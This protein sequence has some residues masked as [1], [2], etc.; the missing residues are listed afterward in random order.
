MDEKILGQQLSRRT[1]RCLGKAQGRAGARV[2][3]HHCHST[4]FLLFFLYSALRWPLALFI[5][6]FIR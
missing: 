2:L 6:P 5:H 4:H 1:L 3:Q